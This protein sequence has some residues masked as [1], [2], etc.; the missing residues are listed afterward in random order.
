M[1]AGLQRQAGPWSLTSF[2]QVQ[3]RSQKASPQRSFEFDLCSSEIVNMTISTRWHKPS[4]DT[5]QVV[6]NGNVPEC[7]A[8]GSSAEALLRRAADEPASSYSGIKLPPERPIGQMDLWWPP[9]VPYTRN[10]SPRA[11][12]EASSGDAASLVP[13]ASDSSLSEIYTSTLGKDHFRLLYISGS[14]GI[15]SPIHGNLVDYRQDNCPEYETV[16]YTWGGEDGDATPCKPGYFG[17][18]WDVLFLTRNCWSLL[19]YLRPHMGTRLVWVDAICINQNNIQERGAQVS[20]MREVYRNCVRVVIYPGDHLVHKDEHK[21]R[22]RIRSDGLIEPDTLFNLTARGCEIRD[23]VFQS[24]YI[25]RVWII[26]ELT[27]APSAVLALKDHD[28]YLHSDNDVLHRVAHEDRGRQWLGLMGQGSKMSTTLYEA[29][30]M[31][32]DSQATDP[33]DKIFGILGVLG[34]NPTYSGIVPDY[35]L[36]MRDCVIGAIGLTL[37]IS[38]EFW[39]LMNIQ[40]SNTT[41]QYPSWLPSLDEVASWTDPVSP[42]CMAV[43]HIR[44]EMPGEW[45]TIIKL[46]DYDPARLNWPNIDAAE[47]QLFLVGPEMSWRQDASIDSGTGALKL[48]LVR[49]FDTPQEL[50]E[51]PC[52]RSEWKAD[53]PRLDLS[54]SYYQVKGS[55]AEVCFVTTPKPPRLEHP[56]HLFLAFRVKINRRGLDPNA[57]ASDLRNSE[58]YLFFADEAETPGTFKLLACCRVDAAMFCSGSP[59]LPRSSPLPSQVKP[60]IHSVLSLFEI[61]YQSLDYKPQEHFW[62]IGVPEAMLF[63]L[64]IP[65]PGTTIPGLLHLGLA[66]ART[67]EPT[68]ITE[69]IRRAYTACLQ[70]R[71]RGYNPVLDDDYVCFALGDNDATGHFGDSLLRHLPLASFDPESQ[72]YRW[73][74]IIPPWLD[75]HIPE[76][77]N[78]HFAGSECVEPFPWLM[79]PSCSDRR[80][81]RLQGY[82]ENNIWP[83]CDQKPKELQAPVRAKMPLKNIV[84]AFRETRLHGLLRFLLALSEKVSEEAETLLERGPQPEDSN[85]Y[86]NE[87]PKSLVDE[88]GF[89]WRSEMVTFV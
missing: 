40:T 48:R 31:T 65:G 28:L 61:L 39:P 18:F 24:R 12:P 23:S 8:C 47:R 15:N 83:P 1:D 88:L 54:E 68:G 34:P 52:I 70:S 55:S 45:P 6:V 53:G 56:C 73:D 77:D 33:R 57:L 35:S 59:L 51:G 71:S 21:F 14:G 79:C 62:K 22:D 38:E 2:D 42:N 9:G 16:S 74:G 64:I 81:Y 86:L 76:I 58:T 4:C 7:R 67:G 3:R 20:S 19:Q 29:L 89:V 78:T 66:V 36:S 27:L 85:V 17:E 46:A 10:G 43:R 72:R 5:P 32:F 80:Y 69:E 87:W 41:S 13:N 11:S 44:F 75:L 25:R 49:L 26:Q 60:G 63:D 50:V 84:E 82:P 30:R 37:L